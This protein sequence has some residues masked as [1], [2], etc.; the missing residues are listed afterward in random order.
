MVNIRDVCHC[1]PLRL[2]PV[3]VPCVQMCVHL[4]DGCL[5]AEPLSTEDGHLQY[6]IFSSKGTFSYLPW[7]EHHLL[8][9]DQV[10]G[11]RWPSRDALTIVLRPGFFISPRDGMM[12]MCY[13]FGA[14]RCAMEIL[15]S[16]KNKLPH[17]YCFPIPQ[18]LM[19]F[20]LYPKLLYPVLSFFIPVLHKPPL[21]P[22]LIHT[23]LASHVKPKPRVLG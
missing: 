2:V 21:T 4:W 22:G 9:G 23:V 17:V 7:R 18:G 20:F 10:G 12:C 19:C 11:A 8:Q 1:L 13:I 5:D 3:S 15:R 6:C 14:F 16:G